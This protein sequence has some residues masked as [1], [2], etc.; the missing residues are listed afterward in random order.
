VPV[1]SVP[2]CAYRKGISSGCPASFL[3]RADTI[4]GN[5]GTGKSRGLSGLRRGRQR[6]RGRVGRGAPGAAICAPLCNFVTG[7]S[8]QAD[9]AYG[10]IVQF[11]LS[12][13]L[14]FVPSRFVPLRPTIRRG[15]RGAYGNE[16]WGRRALSPSPISGSADDRDALKT[17]ERSS[18]ALEISSVSP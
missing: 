15:A 13:L 12:R 18:L 17:K 11:R 7:V 4:E 10:N 1:C 5:R 9:F 16:R 3:L 6:G 8:R 2:F 14:R